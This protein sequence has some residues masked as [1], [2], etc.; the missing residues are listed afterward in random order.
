MTPDVVVV[1][2]LGQGSLQLLAVEVQGVVVHVFA[3]NL[4][5]LKQEIYLAQVSA[6]SA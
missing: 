5:S 2:K 3:R 4:K 6:K 1:R